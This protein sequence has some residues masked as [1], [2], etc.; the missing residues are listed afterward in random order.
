MR[1][2]PGQVSIIVPTYNRAMFLQASLDSLL[3]QTVA[4]AQIIVVNDGSTD[5]TAGVLREYSGRL[6]I[7]DKGN[8]GKSSAINAALPFVHGNFI[9]VFDDD[10]IAC[11]DALARHVQ[12]LE[13]RPDIG[14]TYSGCVRFHD[15]PVAAK[16]VVES[17]HA[18]RPFEDDEYFLELLLSSYVASPAVMVRTEVQHA[19]GPYRPEITRCEDFEIALRWGLIGPA[20]RLGDS[21]PSY[22]RRSHAGLRGAAAD[23]FSVGERHSRE[24]NFE[25]RILNDLQARIELRHYLPR[26]AWD[27]PFNEVAEARAHLRRWVIFTHK[28][29]WNEAL[30]DL[31]WLAGRG[32]EDAAVIG[33]VRAFGPRAIRDKN[34]LAELVANPMAGRALGK[35]LACTSLRELRRCLARQL[36]HL[37]RLE[38]ARR[39][40]RAL[41]LTMRS[42]RDLLLVEWPRSHRPNRTDARS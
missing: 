15:D 13:A 36:Y 41:K 14:F 16:R 11:P 32:L 1:S 39:D 22:W 5:G 25:R 28:G 30:A 42:A 3:T 2:A 18:V 31:E 21:R 40:W 37:A 19:A 20:A 35:Q 38:V 17:V 26:S 27:E 29:L 7:L 34:T 10:D 24:R 6:Q 4:P 9:W 33:D 8:G 23:L 12:V